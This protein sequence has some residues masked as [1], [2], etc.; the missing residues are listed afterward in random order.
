[1]SWRDD[2]LAHYTAICR[3]EWVDGPHDDTRMTTSAK[4][5]IHGNATDPLDA[6]VARVVALTD[7]L[8]AAESVCQTLPGKLTV[9]PTNINGALEEI[10]WLAI[11]VRAAL[12]AENAELKGLKAGGDRPEA[13]ARVE[14]GEGDRFFINRGG[15]GFRA[16]K[17]E[18]GNSRTGAEIRY[19]PSPPIDDS[20]DLF[21]EVPDGDIRIGDTQSVALLPGMK[22]YSAPKFITAG[23]ASA[24]GDGPQAV[25]PEDLADELAETQEME[26]VFLV[27]ALDAEAR[28]STYEEALRETDVLNDVAYKLA[29]D[30]NKASGEVFHAVVRVRKHLRAV[31]ASSVKQE[32]DEGLGGPQSGPSGGES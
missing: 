10:E 8:W 1:M 24:T 29:N 26:A 4:C 3:C 7:A 28:C 17:I 5:A 21:L 20:Y 12:E 6:L 27:R 2:V 16:C 11:R 31:L 18:P 15:Y 30:K 22:F 13:V 25:A 19:L 32:Q 9:K 14:A 23:S